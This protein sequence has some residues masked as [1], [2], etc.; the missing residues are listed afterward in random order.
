MIY[1]PRHTSQVGGSLMDHK[2]FD[3]LDSRTVLKHPHEQLN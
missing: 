2:T 1:P 3:E